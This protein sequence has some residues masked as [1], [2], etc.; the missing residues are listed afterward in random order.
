MHNFP[1]R[2]PQYGIWMPYI[3]AIRMSER[4]ANAC[5]D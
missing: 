4:S 2:S 1:K 3:F 5:G